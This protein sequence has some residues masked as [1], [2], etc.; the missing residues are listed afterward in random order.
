MKFFFQS[1]IPPQSRGS[2]SSGNNELLISRFCVLHSV[3]GHI[4]MK[5]HEVVGHAITERYG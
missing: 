2:G 1:N 4:K 5:K 3:F